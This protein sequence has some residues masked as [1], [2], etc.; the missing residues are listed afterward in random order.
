MTDSRNSPIVDLPDVTLVAVTSVAME[1]TLEAMYLSGQQV[2]FGRSL[3]LSDVRPD[4]VPGSEIE[5][6]QIAPL[7]SREAYSRFMLRDLAKH[8]HTTH[9]LCIQWDGFV[10]DATRWQDAF[11][12]YDYIG[13]PWPH[14]TDGHNVGNG[15]FSLRSKCLLDACAAIEHD[16]RMS[17]D[18]TICREARPL[19]ESRDGIRFAPA[20]VARGF[21]YERCRVRGVEFGFH[22]VFNM[23]DILGAR[24]FRSLFATLERDVIGLR[25]ARDLRSWAIRHVDMALALKMMRQVRH[26]RSRQIERTA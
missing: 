9:V 8:I 18:V 10:L 3:L 25:E 4:I 17:E 20:D 1:A 11:L 7:R 13:A 6:R 21:A 22:G 19:L 12:E 24:R 2:R 26:A 15:G 23:P 5:W 16:G 14:F